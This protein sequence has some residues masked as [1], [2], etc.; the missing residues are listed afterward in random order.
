MPQVSSMILY[1]KQQLDRI[2]EQLRAG[3]LKFSFDG[4]KCIF[5]GDDEILIQ[6]I[7]NFMDGLAYKKG[8]DEFVYNYPHLSNVMKEELV[9]ITVAKV[10]PKTNGT[11]LCFSRLKDGSVVYRTRGSIE[12]DR[13]MN[14]I[15]TAI[16]ANQETVMGINPDVF[17]AFKERYKP[18]LERGRRLGFIDEYGN[19]VMKEMVAELMPHAKSIFEENKTVVAIFGELISPYNPISIDAELRYGMYLGMDA[20]FRYVVFDIL[21]EDSGGAIR[22]VDPGEQKRIV[23]RTTDYMKVSETENLAGLQNM[24]DRYVSE[25]GAIIKGERYLKFKRD[26][27]LEWERL[28]GRLSS[29]LYFSVDHVF[30]Q[31]LGFT[32]KE[33]FDEK[34]LLRKE[35]IDGI[36]N[37]AWQEIAN[38][39]V[40]R[41]D[42]VAFYATMKKP[43]SV[44]DHTLKSAIYNNI[45]LLVAP[46]L[47]E[48]G[49]VK[50]RLYLEIPKYVYFDREP[51]V[52]HEKRQ[53][54][55]SADWYGKMIGMVIGKVFQAEINAEKEA[56]KEQQH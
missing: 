21:E 6:R 44:I 1:T 3:T 32:A 16:I 41:S 22:F 34:L 29:V 5:N 36:T 33:I 48:K 27:V 9:G 52:F 24:L 10:Q 8:T 14:Q 11:N 30:Q 47:Q 46:E 7:P 25:E 13:F 39:G 20:N 43:E 2:R 53:K 19:I 15:N 23:G 12:P 31:G 49:V 4:F 35:A 45:F 26:D 42:L 17:K 56:K 28:M 40:S 54:Y 55:I 50:A 38:N 51:L 37:Q 18:I